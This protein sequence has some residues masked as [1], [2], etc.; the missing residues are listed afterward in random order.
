MQN[1]I[2][3]RKLWPIQKCTPNCEKQ[4]YI[5][6]P[7]H[8]DRGKTLFIAYS[9]ELMLMYTENLHWMMGKFIL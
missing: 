9:I 2:A 7:K 1:S 5:K 3:N 6:T 4:K 8:L